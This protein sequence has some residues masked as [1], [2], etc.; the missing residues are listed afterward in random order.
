MKYKKEA[1]LTSII[2]VVFAL[3]LYIE[4][5][6]FVFK[7]IIPIGENKLIVII[8]N[9]NLLLILL[10]FFLIGRTLFKIYIEKKRGI[11]GSGLK[12]K[13]TI[14]ML[15]ISILPSLALFVLAT[16]FFDMSME[17]WFSQKIEDTIENAQELSRFY[18]EDL[19]QRYERMGSAFVEEIK[20]QNILTNEKRLE[21]Y[22]S[23]KAKAHFLS[24]ISVNDKNGNFIKSNIHFKEDLTERISNL[25]AKNID[26]DTIREI[27]SL[28]QGELILVGNRITDESGETTAM[29]LL[30]DLI[31]VSSGERIQEISAIAREFKDSRPF[32]KVLKYGFVIPLFLIT[33][34]TVFISVWMGIKMATEITIPIERV[35][36]GAEIIGRG[37]FDI[38]LE[39]RGTDEIG[40]LVSAF[41]SMAREL[42]KT[43]DE[44][45]ARRKYMEVILDNVATGI[46]STDKSGRVQLV[47]KAANTILGNDGNSWNGMN[48]KEIFRDDFK[49][50]I[51]SFLKESRG[52]EW[53]S[54]TKDL[55]INLKDDIKHIRVSLTALRGLETETIEGFIIAFD[56]IT[57][58]LR[59]EKLA[60][61]RE[62]ARKLTHEIKNPLTPISLSTE[63]IRR[64][65]LPLLGGQEKE[66]LNE[67]TSV[68]LHS[69]DDIKGIVNELTKLT[70]TSQS[71]TMGD[72]N[73]AVEETLF[74]YRNLY[75]NVRFIFNKG[76]I[77][78]SLMDKD[79]IKR[80][81]TNLITNSVKAVGDKNGVISITTK[82]V[83]EKGINVIEVADN[84]TGIEDH[85]KIKV[86]EPYFTTD[87]QGT[88][89]GL[90]IVH[91]IVLEH[92][93]KIRVED[94]KPEGAKFV[95]EL[96]VIYT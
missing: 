12:T 46:I 4:T 16:G 36:E 53:K 35:K 83:K 55:R 37:K 3:L 26:R 17:K 25:V 58:L 32:K 89:L 95:I 5:R 71:K 27:I 60:T 54:I 11:W 33:V 29:L 39:D 65:I 84:G 61:W 62:V 10:L 88:G 23:R 92:N 22:L 20:E 70:H 93:G 56:D 86:F 31:N 57:H 75:H 94:N 21:G 63:R 79:G 76:E 13:L 47:N 41:N 87:T 40:T 38:N 85:N 91:S 66:I 8:L 24:F 67:T 80:V 73:E 9:I 64:R 82:Y 28:R 7:K 69:V 2:L 30:G 72:I 50:H 19:F 96:P 1:I 90:A 18:Y 78:K 42:K 59:V 77:P 14:T 48:L 51:K 52:N 34:L 15:L 43:K 44:I 81:I 45:E 6:L 68:I 49:K 74:M